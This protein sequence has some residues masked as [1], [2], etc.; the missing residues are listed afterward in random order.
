M[1]DPVSVF[2]IC[3]MLNAGL[4]NARLN[5]DEVLALKEKSVLNNTVTLRQDYEIQY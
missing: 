1:W 5:V 2:A 3:W 4:P